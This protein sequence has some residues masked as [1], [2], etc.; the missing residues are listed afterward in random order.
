MRLKAKELIRILGAVDGDSDVVFHIDEDDNYAYSADS[1]TIKEGQTLD[2]DFKETDMVL[3][4]SVTFAGTYNMK[5]ANEEP[6]SEEEFEAFHIEQA[7]RRYNNDRKKAAEALG[8]SERTLY[9]KMKGF[10][11]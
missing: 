10:G 11:L 4:I 7:L 5:L 8:I 3:H 6:M 2:G 9:R 1:V